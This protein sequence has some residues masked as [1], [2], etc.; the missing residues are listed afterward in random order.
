MEDQEL[1]HMALETKEM[2]Y[3]PCSGY[4]VGAALV[5]E[6][7]KVYTGVNVENASLGATNCA[8][9]TAVFKA[10]SEGE[11]KIVA[12]A[13]AADG[14]AIPYPCGICRQVLAEFGDPGMRIICG[15]S[16][17]KF[18]IHTLEELLPHAFKFR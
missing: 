16:S 14:D 17:G 18:T 2:A 6:R 11:Q 1:L 3:A 8:E 7:G 9:R 15:N 12:I 4:K 10:V 5:T 13:V